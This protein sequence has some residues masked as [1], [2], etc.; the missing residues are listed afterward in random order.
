MMMK[1]RSI[2]EQNLDTQDCLQGYKEIRK[3]IWVHV[4]NSEL[5]GSQF[6][7]LNNLVTEEIEL[8][9]GA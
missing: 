7:L 1:M 8:L 3:T 9:S 2:R 5:D 4:E 6:E